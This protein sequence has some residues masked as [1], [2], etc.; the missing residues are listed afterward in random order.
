[1]DAAEAML[2]FGHI[3]P[4]IDAEAEENKA[5]NT[6]KLTFVNS[7]GASVT[8]PYDHSHSHILYMN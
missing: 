2:S 5:N 3:P 4:G 6:S 1:M 7:G 8:F